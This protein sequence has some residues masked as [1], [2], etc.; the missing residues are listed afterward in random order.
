MKK[1]YL[2]IKTRYGAHICTFDPDSER[3]GFVVTA[4]DVPGVVTCGKDLAE[5]KEM[6]KEALE[7]MIE[8]IAI[9]SPASVPVKNNKYKVA[10]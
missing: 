4:K 2:S 10:A 9:E 5:A 8:T 3:G 6:A 1:R 7:L